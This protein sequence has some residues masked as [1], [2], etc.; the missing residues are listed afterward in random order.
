MTSWMATQGVGC[1]LLVG[2]EDVVGYWYW[3]TLSTGSQR[4]SLTPALCVGVAMWCLHLVISMS[5]GGSR[6]W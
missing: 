2:E 3:H 5:V 6:E 4:Q 1:G